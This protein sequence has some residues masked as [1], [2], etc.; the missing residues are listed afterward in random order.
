MKRLTLILTVVAL[1]VS[2]A[3]IAT[4][5]TVTTVYLNPSTVSLAVGQEQDVQIKV[6]GAADWYGVDMRLAYNPAVVQVVSVTRGVIPM[7]GWVL[8][9]RYDNVAGIAY[10]VMTQLNPQLPANGDGVIVTVRLKGIAPG[11]TALVFVNSQVASRD[12]FLI[13]VTT[14]GGQATVV[15]AIVEPTATLRPAC[16]IFRGRPICIAPID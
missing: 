7:P 4:A 2:S 8:W 12:G 3:P 15:A 16:R 5:Q 6:T 10:Y 14:S 1:L 11:S 9:E 13:P